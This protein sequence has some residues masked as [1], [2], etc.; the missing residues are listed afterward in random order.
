MF[1]FS[2]VDAADHIYLLAEFKVETNPERSLNYSEIMQVWKERKVWPEA[3]C[4]IMFLQLI[5]AWNI[6]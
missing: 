3:V 1:R 2:D 5:H 4:F 6:S